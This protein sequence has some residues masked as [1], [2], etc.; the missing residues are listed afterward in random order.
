MRNKYINAVKLKQYIIHE[1]NCIRI[2]TVDAAYQITL[3]EA[4]PRIIERHF[5]HEHEYESYVTPISGLYPKSFFCTLKC[6]LS[7]PK[8]FR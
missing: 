4:I 2:D 5:L 6:T 8:N 7:Y 1:E 3:D